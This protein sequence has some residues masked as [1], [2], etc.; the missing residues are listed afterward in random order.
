MSLYQNLAQTA[1]NQIN[2]KGRNISIRTVSSGGYDED[3]DT[4]SEETTSD[5][6]VKAVITGYKAME[7]DGDLIQRDDKK[8]LIAASA[9]T[10][11]PTTEKQIVDGSVYAI[12]SVKEIKPADTAVLYEIQAR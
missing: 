8:I 4:Y 3:T 6:T 9:I 11:A 2:D 1:L 5:E 10:S 12:V 7:V